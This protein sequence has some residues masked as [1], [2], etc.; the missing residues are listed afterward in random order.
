MHPF[1]PAGAAIKVAVTTGG[2]R[3]ALAA[4]SFPSGGSIAI[5]PRGSA[6]VFVAWGGI[7]VTCTE[8]TGHVCLQRQTTV[9]QLPGTATH[10]YLI[11][12]AGTTDVQISQGQGL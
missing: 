10:L 5:T 7:G 1:S 11:T 9:F 12:D 2:I 6:D 3:Q 8:A 4:W